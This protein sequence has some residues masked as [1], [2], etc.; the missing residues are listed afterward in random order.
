[1]NKSIIYISIVL[2][3]M[4]FGSCALGESFDLSELYCVDSFDYSVPPP[5]YNVESDPDLD[6][7]NQH[8]YE[9]F[10]L[11]YLNGKYFLCDNYVVCSSAVPPSVD[12]DGWGG[13]DFLTTPIGY[14][15]EWIACLKGERGDVS[16]LISRLPNIEEIDTSNSLPTDFVNSE[17]YV[18]LENMGRQNVR[19]EMWLASFRFKTV[20]WGNW[21]IDVSFP[22]PDYQISKDPWIEYCK[23]ID[24]VEEFRKLCGYGDCWLSFFEHNPSLLHAKG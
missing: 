13:S 15:Q 18:I 19:E 20:R 17:A 14:V 12:K 16:E 1:M 5:N 11:W 9:R 6:W 3:C 22:P 10:W 2:S 24:S 8:G 7:T 4:L 23:T 21:L